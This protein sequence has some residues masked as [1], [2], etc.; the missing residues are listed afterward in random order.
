MRIAAPLS[1]VMTDDRF[2]DPDG[3]GKWIE[4]MFDSWLTNAT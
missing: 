2:V 3:R 1:P 4:D